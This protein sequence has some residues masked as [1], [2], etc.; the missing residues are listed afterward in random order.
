MSTTDIPGVA[1]VT[2][3]PKKTADKTNQDTVGNPPPATSGNKAL[4]GVK[5]GTKIR[6]GMQPGSMYTGGTPKATPET[7]V[8]S[9]ATYTAE[10][11]YNIPATMDNAAKANLLLQMSLIPGLYAKGQAPTQAYIR[12]MGNAI[13]LRP[14]DYSAFTKILTVA[15]ST[16]QNYSTALGRFITNPALSQQYFGKITSTPKQVAVSSPDNLKA[17]LNSRFLDMFDAPAD[18]KTVS[19]YV[20]EIN[21][22]ELKAGNAGQS[23]S[24]Q[25]REDIFNK[26]VA[27]AANARYAKVKG[28]TDTTDDTLIEKGALGSTVRMIRNAYADNG[29]PVKESDVYKIAI[30]ATRSQQA[31]QNA[32]DDINMQASIQFPA[33]KDWFAKGKTAKTFFA[34]YATAFSKIYGVPEDQVD[35]SKFYDVA[36]G[37]SVVPVNQWI[38]NQWSNPAIKD[39]QY[40]KEINRNDLRTVA[41]A[42]GMMV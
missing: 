3:K 24:N 1:N 17:E 11:V 12:S 19:A 27:Q 32:L 29:I 6:T 33:L 21:N 16:G 28:T 22:L 25:Q 37:T 40:Y 34:P 2:V 39:T 23:I 13:S 5:V 15:D 7:P 20:K 14:E 35:V 36:S 38:K 26:Y 9:T 10:S 42:F 4:S 30:G 41:E 8:Y 18:A 31:L